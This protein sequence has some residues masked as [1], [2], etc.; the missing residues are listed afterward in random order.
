MREAQHFF[1]PPPLP[2]KL[3]EGAKLNCKFKTLGF[4][5]TNKRYTY[6]PI[7][8]QVLSLP[9]LQTELAEIKQL[10]NFFMLFTLKFQI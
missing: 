10:T 6:S 7:T 5:D 9:L 3:L 4:L 8:F 2:M 1:L